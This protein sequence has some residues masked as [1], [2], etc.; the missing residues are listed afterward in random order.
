MNLNVASGVPSPGANSYQAAR[1][2]ASVAD[3]EAYMKQRS[4]AKVGLTPSNVAVNK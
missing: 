2:T 4:V 1:K 3:G